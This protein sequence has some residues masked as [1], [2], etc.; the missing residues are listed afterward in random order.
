[1]TRALRFYAGPSVP[2]SYLGCYDMNRNSEAT[3][4][5]FLAKVEHTYSAW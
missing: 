1:V 5:K 4:K 2:V 3:L